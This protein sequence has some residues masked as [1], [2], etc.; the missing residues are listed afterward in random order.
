MTCHQLTFE[1]IETQCA[2][3]VTCMA[4]S[5]QN[6][7]V[8]FPATERHHPLAGTKLYLL[9]TE[10]PRCEKVAHSHSLKMDHLRAKPTWPINCEST[11]QSSWCCAP[12]KI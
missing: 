3:P 12:Y 7:Y 11:E 5:E 1:S 9:V 2:T 8:T 6:S 10:T 4:P